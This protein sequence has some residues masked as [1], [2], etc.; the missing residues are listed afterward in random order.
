MNNEKEEKSVCWRRLRIAPKRMFFLCACKLLEN[1]D[2][3]MFAICSVLAPQS[4]PRNA[5]RVQRHVLYDLSESIKLIEL[6]E[7]Q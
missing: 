4:L 5:L 1:Y 2:T 3:L 6:T 7:I